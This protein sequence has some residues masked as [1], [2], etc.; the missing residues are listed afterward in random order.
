MSK[1]LLLLS[2]TTN[3]VTYIDVHYFKV[4]VIEKR[5]TTMGYRRVLLET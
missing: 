5:L 3:W 1:I 2:T 4:K